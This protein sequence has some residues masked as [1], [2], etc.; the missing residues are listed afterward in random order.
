M[1]DTITR[2]SEPLHHDLGQVKQVDLHMLFQEGRQIAWELDKSRDSTDIADML[3]WTA[4]HDFPEPRPPEEAERLLDGLW[5][6]LTV[7]LWAP[8]TLLSLNIRTFLRETLKNVLGR[9]WCSTEN[10]YFGL[11][12]GGTQIGDRVAIFYGGPIPFIV[13]PHSTA[14]DANFILVGHGYFGGLRKGEAFDLPA[15]EPQK[16]VL[17]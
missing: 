11:V 13:R 17:V 15:F 8:D 1:F 14:Q 6:L 9:S 3:L 2:L 5:T 16:I 10:G 4:L 7:S 12:P